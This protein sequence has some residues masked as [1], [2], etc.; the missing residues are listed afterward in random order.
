MTNGLIPITD[1]QAKLSQEIVK[2]FRDLGSFFGRALG[3]TPEDLVGYYGGDRLR[4]RR[5]ENIVKMMCEAQARLAVMGIEETKPAT[6]SIA[7]PILEGA[8]DEDREELVDLWAR[9]LANAMDPNM[10]SVR[11]SFVDAV[12]KMDPLDAVVLRHIHEQN[13]TAV[14]RGH[15]PDNENQNTG[16][17][18]ISIAIGHRSD[19]VEVSLRHLQDLLLFDYANNTWVVNAISREFLRACYPEV[20]PE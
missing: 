6:L 10:N 8:A 13:I 19:E 12:K 11:Y 2:A 5:A 14:R 7:L 16:I 17:D 9:L 4:I 18:D 3:S 20:K 1:E 15:I